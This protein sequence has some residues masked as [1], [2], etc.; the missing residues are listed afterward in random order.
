[1]AGIYFDDALRQPA[2]LCG[3]SE[4]TLQT[5]AKTGASPAPLKVHKGAV[6]YS[7][8]EYVAWIAGGVKPGTA[9]GETDKFSYT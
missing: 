9:Y 4:R 1:M 2:E 5:W 6:R 7:R 3:V 8:P